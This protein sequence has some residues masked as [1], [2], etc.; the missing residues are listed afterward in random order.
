[1][2][3]EMCMVSVVDSDGNLEMA[4]GHH[5]K[6]EPSDKR[7]LGLRADH[8]FLRKD[9]LLVRYVIWESQR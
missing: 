4:F 2:L 7:I 6:D 5:L 1:M 8:E 9:G 3:C